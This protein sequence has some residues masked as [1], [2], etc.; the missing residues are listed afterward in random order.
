MIVAVCVQ[1]QHANRIT[2]LY[3][4]IGPRAENQQLLWGDMPYAARWRKLQQLRRTYWGKAKRTLKWL[5]KAHPLGAIF[6]ITAVEP[7]SRSERIL[8]QANTFILMLV[9]T[10][11]FYYSKAVNCCK[12]FREFVSCPDSSDVGAPCLGFEYCAELKDAA[13]AKLDVRGVAGHWIH[14]VGM[15]LPEEALPGDFFCTAF[16]QS[17]FVGR[18]WVILII[19]GILTPNT[20]ILSQMFIMAQ[21]A[22]IPDHWGIYVTK[23]AEQ[24]FGAKPMAVIQSVSVTLYALFFNFQKFNKALAVTFVAM[25]GFMLKPHHIRRAITFVVQSYKISVFYVRLFT[26]QDHPAHVWFEKFIMQKQIHDARDEMVEEMMKSML[27]TMMLVMSSFCLLLAH[28][29]TGAKQR[30]EKTENEELLEKVHLISPVEE[31]LQKLA[32]FAILVSWFT[33]AW[34]L[35]TF[36]MLIREMMGQEAEAELVASW[37]TVLA[38]E[39]FGKETMKL[40]FIRL[41]VDFVMSKVERKLHSEIP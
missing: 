34:V 11:W 17:T 15:M 3:E 30:T 5:T 18:F 38:V 23:K 22:S 32:Y 24:C 33:C 4:R 19:V 16:P 6:L 14:N 1:Q 10:V 2:E 20:M 9:F 40:I 13:P 41:F 25:I 39:M 29:A 28:I 36:S 21:N 12:D 37:A 8:I 27:K 7:F 31:H 35:L 26:G